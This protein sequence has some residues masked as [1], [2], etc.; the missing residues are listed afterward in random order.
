[1][2]PKLT[3]L[4]KSSYV[5]ATA[6]GKARIV[7]DPHQAQELGTEYI[8]VCPSTDPGWTTLFLNAVGLVVERGGMLSHGAIV[9]R[10]FG[11]PAVLCP[12]ATKRLEDGAIIQVD[13]NS[14]KIFV[15][16]ENKGV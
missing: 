12:G 11:I 7:R 9:A 6:K 16:E 2:I 10:D 15:V 1:M 13:G 14:G 3:V 5:L 4:S 8:L